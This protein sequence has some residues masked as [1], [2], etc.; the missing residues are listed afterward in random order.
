M[1][2][3]KKRCPLKFSNSGGDR[4]CQ[5]ECA[6]F[7]GIGCGLL[8][9]SINAVAQAPDGQS[10]KVERLIETFIKALKEIKG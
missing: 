9:I 8:D 5:A 1:S 10:Q 7:D 6:W 2:D 3:N 4:Y